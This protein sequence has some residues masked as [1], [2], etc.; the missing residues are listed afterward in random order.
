MSF[1][2]SNNGCTITAVSSMSIVGHYAWCS[3]ATV[4]KKEVIDWLTL[5][6]MLRQIVR[7]SN[8][9]ENEKEYDKMTNK[10]FKSFV[11]VV[12]KLEDL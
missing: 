10:K 9:M 7:Q 11:H 6:G 4:R 2:C 3:K 5:Q 8:Y 12:Q 1:K